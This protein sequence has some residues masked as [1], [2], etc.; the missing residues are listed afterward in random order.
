MAMTEVYARLRASIERLWQWQ[1]KHTDVREG[2][3]SNIH[4]ESGPLHRNP[5]FACFCG[6]GVIVNIAYQ[7]QKLRSWRRRDMERV[8]C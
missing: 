8:V 3:A 7:S 6:V 4:R 1:A 2:E 5:V